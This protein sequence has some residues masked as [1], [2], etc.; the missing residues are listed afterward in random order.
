MAST[1]VI[2]GPHWWYEITYPRILN[3]LQ[4]NATAQET[5][6]TIDREVNESLG[7]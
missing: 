6:E 5:L 4:G 2:S 3:Y 7:G 1:K